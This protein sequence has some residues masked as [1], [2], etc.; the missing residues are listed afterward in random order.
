M[1]SGSVLT[2]SDGLAAMIIGWSLIRPMVTKSVARSTGHFVPVSGTTD[3]F[4]E[5]AILSV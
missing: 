1:N 2:P 5:T 4:D 3:E